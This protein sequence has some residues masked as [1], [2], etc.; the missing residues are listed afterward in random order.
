MD[1]GGELTIVPVAGEIEAYT[2]IAGEVQEASTTEKGTRL[3]MTAGTMI[4]SQVPAEGA[5]HFAVNEGQSLL[6]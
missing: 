4:H 2:M 1:D 3:V 6:A 5:G